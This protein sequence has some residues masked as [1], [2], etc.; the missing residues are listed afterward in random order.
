ML[1]IKIYANRASHEFLRQIGDVKRIRPIIRPSQLFGMIK[2]AAYGDNNGDITASEMAHEDIPGYPK[3]DEAHDKTMQLFDGLKIVSITK[4]FGERFEDYV[5]SSLAGGTPISAMDKKPLK[6]LIITKAYWENVY[7]IVYL[8]GDEQKLAIIKSHLEKPQAFL[9]VGRKCCFIDELRVEMV[10]ETKMAEEIGGGD[11][12]YIGSNFNFGSYCVEGVEPNCN[13]LPI[14]PSK[15]IGQHDF[16]DWYELA[17]SGRVPNYRLKS[18]EADTLMEYK[19]R[20]ENKRDLYDRYEMHRSIMGSLKRSRDGIRIRYRVDGNE[21]IVRSPVRLDWEGIGGY[22]VLEESQVE[23][24]FVA[25]DRLKFRLA[26]CPNEQRNGK[27]RYLPDGKWCD[28]LVRSTSGGC[29]VTELCYNKQW[30]HRGWR[31][32]L[33]A[34]FKG[35]LRVIDTGVFNGMLWNGIGRGSAWGYGLLVVSPVIVNGLLPVLSP[36]KRG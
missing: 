33:V 30:M 10:G 17:G 15:M 26:A 29:E 1:Q 19:L 8:I 11:Y 13:K 23:N 32:E 25:G 24:S 12:R 9:Y 21:I 16:V 5:A 3:S 7:Y 27:K 14:W 6:S 35:E 34:E 36:C 22:Y 2:N 20:V 18:R 31:R 4:S 28:W